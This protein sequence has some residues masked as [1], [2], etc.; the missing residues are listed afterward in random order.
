MSMY[1]LMG[2]T[3]LITIAGVFFILGFCFSYIVTKVTAWYKVNYGGP[4]K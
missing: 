4:I 2:S 1:T 3:S